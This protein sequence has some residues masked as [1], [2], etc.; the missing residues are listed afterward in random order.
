[1]SNI[2]KLYLVASAIITFGQD[3]RRLLDF[4]IPVA[5][6]RIVCRKTCTLIRQSILEPR[7]LISLRI[8]FAFKLKF[9]LIASRPP[10]SRLPSKSRTL[11]EARSRLRYGGGGLRRFQ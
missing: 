1:L 8:Y 9:V 4:R 5:H 10:E 2:N 3:R 7:E 6:A 11:A